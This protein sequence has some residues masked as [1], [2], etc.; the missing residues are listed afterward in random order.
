MA[1]KNIKKSGPRL[2]KNAVGTCS[3]CNSSAV[4]A[5]RFQRDENRQRQKY[6]MVVCSNPQCGKKTP[7]YAT[8][9][10]A[11]KEWQQGWGK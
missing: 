3:V 6:H 11:I 2:L 10:Q 7:L 9:D 8:A 1:W 4:V 5:L